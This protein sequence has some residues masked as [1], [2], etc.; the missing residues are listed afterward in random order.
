MNRLILVFALLALLACTTDD[1]DKHSTPTRT[2]PLPTYPYSTPYPKIY[3]TSVPTMTTHPSTF[4]TSVPTVK[5]LGI[6]LDEI[7]EI[8]STFGYKSK[9]TTPKV[10]LLDHD[11][12]YFA[13]THNGKRQVT[14]AMTSFNAEASL[15]ESTAIVIILMGLVPSMTSMD[16][17]WSGLLSGTQV[18]R[19]YDDVM[20]EAKQSGSRTNIYLEPR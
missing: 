18:R 14:K 1:G 16:W 20:V 9:R 17:I 6:N 7:T 5:H 12:S 11:L 3:A 13:I 15:E 2:P 4:P 19:V 8:A 10:V